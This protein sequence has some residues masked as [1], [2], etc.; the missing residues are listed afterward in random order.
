MRRDGGLRAPIVFG[1]IG[2][3]LGGVAGAV[4]QL[5]LSTLMA[6]MQGPA[7]AREQALIGAFSTGLLSSS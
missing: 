6:G 2:S 5:L 3:V 7:A 1:V 4:Y